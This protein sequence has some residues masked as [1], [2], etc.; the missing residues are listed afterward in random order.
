M[1]LPK[2]KQQATANA[3]QLVIKNDKVEK[4]SVSSAKRRNQ[5]RK[6][7]LPEQ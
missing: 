7:L 5:E 6:A 1:I 2:K 3:L 4:S